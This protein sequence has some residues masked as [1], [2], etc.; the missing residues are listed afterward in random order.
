MAKKFRTYAEYKRFL[1][2]LENREIA[3]SV[4]KEGTGGGTTVSGDKKTSDDLSDNLE[5]QILLER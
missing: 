1:D 4:G 2:D 5:K 3:V